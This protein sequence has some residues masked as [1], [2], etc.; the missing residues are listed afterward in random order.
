[1]S[2]AR[3]GAVV[4]YTIFKNGINYADVLTRRREAYHD[5]ALAESARKAKAAS[6]RD[7]SQKRTADMPDSG[8]MASIHELEHSMTLLVRPAID[9]DDRALF[10][11]RI[12]GADVTPAQHA[13]A[14]YAPL[15]SWARAPLDFEL[16]QERD[17]LEIVCTGFGLTKRL[18]FMEDG[19]MMVS[20]TWDASKFEIGARFAS[21]VS[22]FRP[23]EIDADS[24]ETRWMAPVETVA[25]SE[26][27]LDRTV[28]GESVTLLWSASLGA[29]SL[30]VRRIP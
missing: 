23:L 20:W 21:E 4:E 3:G 1:V 7:T 9:L 6:N 2:P 27:G 13:L 22:L 25:K 19:S 15:K 18:R 12:L 11:D 28:Q 14:A 29:A 16:I 8:G 10:V 17:A 30:R 5:E 26:K 24:D